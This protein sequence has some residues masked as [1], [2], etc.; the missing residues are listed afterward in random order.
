MLLTFV[1]RCKNSFSALQLSNDQARILIL[2]MLFLRSKG[3][4]CAPFQNKIIRGFP[5]FIISLQ[6]INSVYNCF[7][8]VLNQVLSAFNPHSSVQLQM[9]SV[10]LPFTPMTISLMLSHLFKHNIL[11]TFIL[12]I[13]SNIEYTL[14]CLHFL[15]F[16]FCHLK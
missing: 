7:Y 9:P 3:Y 11:N 16:S 10:S 6:L 14:H 2:S 5:G 13:D 4:H 1:E 12:P 8:S 15:S